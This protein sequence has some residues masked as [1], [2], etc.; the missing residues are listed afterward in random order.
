MTGIRGHSYRDL[1]RDLFGETDR[2]FA[3]PAD[4]SRDCEL[5]DEYE[6]DLSGLCY[7]KHT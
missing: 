4:F 7:N 5:D 2:L 6:R 1:D 3:E